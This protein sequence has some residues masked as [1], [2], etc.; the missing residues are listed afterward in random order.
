MVS[1]HQ[2]T[3]SIIAGRFLARNLFKGLPFFGKIRNV[4]SSSSSGCCTRKLL[5]FLYVGVSL[6]TSSCYYRLITSLLSVLQMGFP[7]PNSSPW[8][9][10]TKSDSSLNT[11][12][13]V[14][15]LWILHDG[16]MDEKRKE[17][18]Y[19]VERMGMVVVYSLSCVW[20]LWP[21]GL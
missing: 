21:H 19:M 20:L 14:V 15:Y 6:F 8:R 16:L 9:S 5:A 2:S 3:A 10:G 17:N 7:R 1:R 13:L 11:S 18:E 12:D 4:P